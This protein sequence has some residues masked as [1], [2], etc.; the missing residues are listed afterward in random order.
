MLDECKGERLEE[1]LAVFS[2]AVLKKVVED[3]Q[4]YSKQHP[5]SA[6]VIAL[7]SRGYAGER[8]ELTPLILAHKASLRAKLDQKAIARAQY[9]KFAAVLDAR[10]R[11][12]SK[13][14][15]LATASKSRLSNVSA[16]DKS[17]VRRTVRNN[18]AGNEQWQ[19][20]LI[21]GDTKTAKDGVL[22]A[23]VDRVWRR[24]R[25]NRLG[26]LDSNSGGLLRQLDD[27]VRA[28]QERL[29]KWQNFQK[30]MFGEVSSRP[31]KR[32]D[33]VGGQKGIDLGFKSHES[34][35]LGR[36]NPEKLVGTKVLRTRDGYDD[37]LKSLETEL[38]KINQVPAAPSLR[39][40]RE[41][42]RR[43]PAPLLNTEDAVAQ[44]SATAQELVPDEESVSDL[45]ELEE[46]IAKAPAPMNA[47]SKTYS[48]SAESKS[49]GLQTLRKSSRPTLPQPLSTMPAFRPKPQTSEVSP[50]ETAKPSL[51]TKR[52][53]P[54]PSRSV[55]R[56]PTRSIRPS[57][58]LSP[59]RMPPARRTES[60]EMLPPSPTQQQADQ[61]L[62]SMTAASPSPIK[63]P[64]PRHTL[65]LAERTRLS[66]SRDTGIGMDDEDGEGVLSPMRPSRRNTSS[67]SP[68]KNKTPTSATISED[69]ATTNFDNTDAG[70]EGDDLVARTRKSMANFEVAQQKARLDRE[71]SLKRAARQQ[72]GPISRQPYFPSLDEEAAASGEDSST[73]VLEELIAKEQSVDYDAVFRS[74]PKIKT[75]PPLTPIRTAWGVDEEEL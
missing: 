3:Q 17:N 68:T 25:A 41:R 43:S 19:D 59:S 72:S 39:H 18:W 55:D 1:V 6:Q 62:A 16:D 34:L 33:H 54:S 47:A 45:S 8:T 2:S 29:G 52:D 21:Y 48:E 32:T 5:A 69:S 73:I 56:S 4:T 36:T 30:E 64:R 50:I 13:R 63:Q 46:Q 74:R 40:L 70:A 42:G 22:T 65:S 35:Q 7:E 11:E 38:K 57:P 20:A 31:A 28:Q 60:P 10:E 71:R 9:E 66:L 12:L 61:I 37:I 49:N 26:E 58:S 53:L 23:P 51:P 27:R 24:V 44:E 67:R 75:S 15:E 14:R